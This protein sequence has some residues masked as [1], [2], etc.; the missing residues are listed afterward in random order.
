MGEPRVGS[1]GGAHRGDRQT[2]KGGRQKKKGAGTLPQS[3]PGAR[4]GRIHFIFFNTFIFFRGPGIK[5]NKMPVHGFWLRAGCGPI[6]FIFD[7]RGVEP[8]FF[9]VVIPKLHNTS[10][11]ER[12]RKHARDGNIVLS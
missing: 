2:P 12:R 1:I 10:Y 7:P 3:D 4:G 9:P 5:K 8:I 6:F 11:K